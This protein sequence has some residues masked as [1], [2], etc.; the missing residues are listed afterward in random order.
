[1]NRMRTLAVAVLASLALP[2][3]AEMNIGVVDLRQALF[4]SNAAQKFSDQLKSDFSRDENEVRAAQEAARKL[5]ERLEKDGSMM[6]DAERT[7]LS[8]EFEDKVKEF[9]YLKN[10]L[11]TSVAKRKQ[12]FLQE[13]RPLVDESLKKILDDR[14][15]DLILP[16]EAVVYVVPDKD[17]TQALIDQLNKKR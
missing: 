9:N 8:S 15:L 1:M 3:A 7:K 2:A 16:R 17:L 11:D 4:T 5:Q 12:T 13:S 14:K 10:K 6:N